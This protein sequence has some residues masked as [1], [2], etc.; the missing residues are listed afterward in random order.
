MVETAARRRVLAAD[1]IWTR[2]GE[3]R[4]NQHVLAASPRTIRASTPAD[5]FD[6][7]VA[8]LDSI[9]PSLVEWA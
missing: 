5:D 6:P 1:A 3:D 7:A 9:L 2:L 4:R 8:A